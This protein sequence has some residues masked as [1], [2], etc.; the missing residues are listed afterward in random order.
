MNQVR[1]LVERLSRFEICDMIMNTMIKTIR[2]IGICL[3]VMLSNICVSGQGHHIDITLNNYENDTLIVGYYFADRQLVHDTLSSESGVFTLKGDSHISPGMYIA[4]TKPKNDYFQF[5]VNEKDQEFSIEADFDDLRDLSA[6]G[7]IDNE[8]FFEYLAYIAEQNKKANMLNQMVSASENGVGDMEEIKK[9]QKALNEEVVAYQKDILDNNPGTLTAKLIKSNMEVNIPEFDETDPSALETKRYYYYK[10]HF[11]ENID[12]SDSVSLRTPFYDNRI[13]TFLD[14]ITTQI[15]DTIIKS[16][17]VV[18]GMMENN[19]PAFKF[20]L[21]TLLGKYGRSKIVGM[22]AIYVHIIQKYY[23][24]GKA[25]WVTEDN[26]LKLTDNAKKMAPALI[27]KTGMNIKTR[28]QD[29]TVVSLYDITS[30]YTVLYFFSHTCGHCKKSTP[31]LV[32]FANKFPEVT[33]MSVCTKRDIENCWKYNEEYKMDNIINTVDPFQESR[34]GAKY[35]VTETPR[36]YI[37][38]KKKKILMKNFPTEELE[39][40]MDEI[41]KIEGQRKLKEQ[42]GSK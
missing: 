16:V 12:L 3:G 4:I 39:N 40:I 8:I 11:F 26:L 5:M 32:D 37:L 31:S 9:Q 17:D 28:K 27:G 1:K 14:K 30:D 29:S 33:V 36:I 41:I 21:S 35:H 22:D 2:F 24:Q 25:P 13:Q 42:G 15:P 10:N 34:F 23:A 6:E 20:Y 18:L 38:D 19:P 7:S